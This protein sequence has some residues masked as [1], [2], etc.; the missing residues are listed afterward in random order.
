MRFRGSKAAA[1][2]RILLSSLL[3]LTTVLAKSDSPTVKVT[4]SK[5]IP[6]GLNYFEDSD[7]IVYHDISEKN[8]YRSDD[9]GVTWK[10]VG[11]IPDRA[12]YMLIMHEFNRKRAYAITEGREHWKTEDLGA[13]WTKFDSY[14]P[15]TV[16]RTD[17]L[18]FH[19]SDPDRIIFNGMDC[20]GIFCDEVCTYTTDGFKGKANP[21]RGNTAGC[22]WA[23]ASKQFS[24][25]QDDLDNQRILCI[26][27]DAFS[28][29][30]ED[31]RLFAS[32]NFFKE[33]NGHVQEFEP[34][35]DTNRGVQ[36]VVNLAVVSRYLVVATTSLNTDEMA[37]FVTDDTL[38]WHRA[39]FPAAHGH[40]VNQGAYTVLESTDY[41][42]QVDVM[43]TRPGNPMGVMF[44]S[45]SN[46]TYF[47]E[48]IEHTNRNEKG[49]VDFEKITGIQGI[50]LLNTV[51]NWKEVE[52][53]PRQEKK[54]VTKIT[55]DDGR[56]F[57]NIKADGDIL[58]L[59]SVTELDNV[60]RVFSSPAPGLVMGIGNVGDHLKD[61]GDG[62]LYVSDNAGR[63]WKKALDGPH[64]YEFGDQGSILVAVKD[65]RD[66]D[67]SEVSYSLDH[68]DNWK[69]LSFPDSLK[70]HP[71]FLTTTQDSTSLKFLLVGSSGP[72]DEET[73]HIIVIDFEGMHE[74]KCTDGDMIDW[75]AR[76][77]DDGN[78]SCLMGQKQS[79]RRRKKDADCFVQEVFKDPVPKTE[80]CDC[81][82]K[83]FECD[84]NF[85]RNGENENEC[86]AAGPLAAEGDV[87]KNAKP[88]D[89]FKGSSG[90]RKIPGNECNR[91][92]GKQKDDPVE[93]KCS[94]AVE[95]PKAPA[96]GKIET[97]PTT[98]KSDF[99]NF[100][101]IYLESGDS[102]SDKDETILARPV[103]YETKGRMRP[104]SQIWRTKD[105]GKHWEKILEEETIE[106]II[107]HQYFQDTVFFTSAG[108]SK[109]I[110]YTVD[111]GDNYHHF[112]A[113]AKPAN[114]NPLSFHPDK[115]D[116]LIWL[117]EEDCNSDKCPKFASIS[118]DRGDHWRTIVHNVEKCEFTG[119]TAYNFRN[120][121]QVVCMS[122][123]EENPDHPKKLISS[124][125]FFVEDSATHE[126]YIRDFATMAEFIVVAAED[127]SGKKEG[128][129]K[130]SAGGLKALASLDGETYAAAHFPP[131]FKVDHQNAYT[132]LDSSTHAVNL[133]VATE[134]AEGARYGSI[135]KSNSNGTSYVLS[136][137]GVNC[138]DNWYVDFEK[139]S[140]LEGVGIINVV[141][142]R[143]RRDGPKQLQTKIT[144]NDGALWGFLPPPR[145]DIEGKPYSCRSTMGDEDCALHIHGY[146][147]REDRKKTYGAATAVGLM[148]GVGN[149]GSHLGTR[150]EADTF[151]TTD[152]GITWKNVKKGTWTWQYGDKGSL[153][154][155]V[156]LWSAEN[157]VKTRTLFYTTN[158]GAKWE[159]FTFYDRDVTVLDITTMRSGKSRNFLLWCRGENDDIFTVSLDFSGLMERPC[160]YSEE[161]DSDFYT[162]SPKH[163]LQ[164]NDCL[165][166]HVTKYIRK[167]PDLSCYND[168][169]V[170]KLQ[171]F[172]NCTCGR[173]DYE[174]YVES[175]YSMICLLFPVIIRLSRANIYTNF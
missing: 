46:G 67:V 93:R 163:P 7:V 119:R 162:W 159:E 20:T 17:I 19:G 140:G 157:S 150:K 131:N 147:E 94:D 120:L 91:A 123:D 61:F 160:Q 69:K 99:N 82:D 78:P 122:R 12:V 100:E 28:P 167:K 74:R 25:G 115:K 33:E 117:G 101:K 44:T 152:A 129:K 80:K 88:G 13:T 87:C 11:D 22:W 31:Q 2:W 56:T 5:H 146:T 47:T 29:F 60:G 126:S 103:T 173:Q 18:Q 124:N 21:L 108:G 8:I 130:E 174:W 142:N 51:E 136:A 83:D 53:S 156:R 97:H 36:G 138:N 96:S 155:L 75:H 169:K 64:K 121:K 105:H 141:K 128:E 172:S 55:Y 50:F 48:N 143:D 32:D 15:T 6:A 3:L 148:L 40:K 4:S 71:N 37:L 110:W 175:V 16:F 73:Y 42:I 171:Q 14:A 135:L 137:S 58:H 166:G 41:S 66:V 43:T 68:G 132:V 116:W 154:V 76:T 113:P 59:H 52:K 27:R 38:K 85:V 90:W 86:V 118:I 89:T 9:A 114:S 107:P 30:K 81:T 134:M 139:V 49:R 125:D 106:R 63:S 98:F 144:H 24:T 95:P 1:S 104:D 39:M 133:F 23:K 151:M 164:N 102:S 112:D 45:N 165:F 54:V 72:K 153:V 149:V 10:R 35:M 92:S 109:K 57:E 111:R 70:I 65:S 145:E 168:E 84:Y 170:Q 161:G 158:E 62:N 34:D 79:Y 77:D 26:V 127:R